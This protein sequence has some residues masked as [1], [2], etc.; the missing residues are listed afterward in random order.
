METVCVYFIK[1]I[2][3]ILLPYSVSESY[4]FREIINYVNLSLFFIW[5]PAKRV[6]KKKP[7]YLIVFVVILT[8]L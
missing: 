4:R 2:I 3:K 5:L 1:K 7:K 6:R 8:I